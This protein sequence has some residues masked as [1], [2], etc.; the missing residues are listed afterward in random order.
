MARSSLRNQHDAALALVLPLLANLIE[1]EPSVVPFDVAESGF[2]RAQGAGFVREDGTPWKL[3]GLLLHIGICN[4]AKGEDIGWLFAYMDAIG[5]NTG[6]VIG[7]HLSD[8]KFERSRTPA[9]M[10]SWP[11]RYQHDATLALAHALLARLSGGAA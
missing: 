11:L 9:R 6:V 3:A 7:C 2:I 4:I 1:L 10:G 8:W 5:A